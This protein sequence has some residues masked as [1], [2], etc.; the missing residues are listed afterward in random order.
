MEIPFALLLSQSSTLIDILRWRADHQ[1][2]RCAFRYLEDG[3]AEAK[4]LTFGELD[5]Q[6]QAIAG[7]LYTQGVS[8]GRALLLYPPGLE[9]ISAFFGCL[10]A[11]V[12]AVPTYP[13]DPVRLDRTLP[14][15]LSILRNA[16]L[17]VG[18]TT[19]PILAMIRF[20]A[21]QYP[22]LQTLP[23]LQTDEIL[24]GDLPSSFPVHAVSRENLAFIQFTSG[25]TAEPRGVML[26]HANL[27]HN[28]EMI[29][30]ALDA[31][32]NTQA[33][34]WLPF[35]H[36]MGL[37]GGILG[38]VYCGATNNLMSPLRFLQHPLEWLDNIAR[39]QADVSGGPNFAYDLCVRKST[40]EQRAALDL[41]GWRLAFN[42][43]EQVR[44]ETLERFAG[45]FA[46]SGFRREAFYPCYGL[47]EA[48]LFVTGAQRSHPPVYKAVKAA[49]LGQGRLVEAG[50]G[51]LNPRILVSSGRP[52]SDQVVQIVDPESLEP[53]QEGQIGEVWMAGDSVAQGYWNQAE[54]SQRTFQAYLDGSR[55]N[56]YPGPYLR[57][58]DLGCFQ[59]GEL[60]IT[61]RLK[62]MIILQGLNHYPQ[63]IEITVEKS[64]SALRP[65]SC[66]AFSVDVSGKEQVV[67]VAEAAPG[68]VS[69]EN[70]PGSE[71]IQKAIRRAVSEEHELRL[72]EI[73]L[74][75]PGALPKTS[76]G[77]IQRYLCR[78]AYLS[79]TLDVWST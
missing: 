3:Q 22:E 46:V 47:A 12:V 19:T 59:D 36:D 52:F 20:L 53:C 17:S 30:Q 33:V 2:D 68:R 1:A 79:N 6:A 60:Y 50:T 56:I 7:Q 31:G 14:R 65:G 67:V 11:G 61:G 25:S 5:R 29:R 43:A 73:V 40:P 37:I 49:E 26:T 77:K 13:P 8:G 28:L 54:A 51:E 35:Y 64:H 70:Q 58:G 76:S 66:A 78:Q 41:S 15:F 24:Q 55:V 21:G 74:I 32:E 63:D 62:D 42:G 69:N 10:Y 44:A 34:F 71:E 16:Q 45:A 18:L 39:L 38:P 48:T 4:V 23:W 75:K 57:T 27:M 72:H 9:Y